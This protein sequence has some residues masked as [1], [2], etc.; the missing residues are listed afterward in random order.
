MPK[1]VRISS[2]M[3]A[4]PVSAPGRE[5]ASHRHS[6]VPNLLV[7]F[8]TILLSNRTNQYSCNPFLN[9]GVTWLDVLLWKSRNRD[10]QPNDMYK[11]PKI[12]EINSVARNFH[13]VC[14]KLH[15]GACCFFFL[16]FCYI[17]FRLSYDARYSRC[18]LGK[19]LAL[20]WQ[21]E[22]QALDGHV[23]PRLDAACLP[24]VLSGSS[25]TH[26]RK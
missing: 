19:R 26:S 10:I 16:Q 3:A 24:R 11:L 5:D 7:Y 20:N 13:K 21:V 4:L 22:N 12:H 18:T 6:Q 23:S 25:F 9:W 8:C 17:C 2:C 15:S 1:Y 14:A